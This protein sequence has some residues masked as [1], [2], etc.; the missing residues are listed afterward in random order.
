M[1]YIYIVLFKGVVDISYR[2]NYNDVETKV[3]SGKPTKL[4]Y[5][6]FLPYQILIFSKTA[7]IKS[8]DC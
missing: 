7:I 8:S 6:M 2:P 1:L 3:L 5:V 4:D